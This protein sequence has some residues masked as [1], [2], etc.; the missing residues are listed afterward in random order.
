LWGVLFA[1]LVMSGCSHSMGG[2][3]QIPEMQSGQLGSR[4]AMSVISTNGST[5]TVTGT[6]EGGTASKFNVNAGSGC[7]MVNVTTTSSTA[8][9]YNGLTLSAG[10]PVTFTATG[11]CGTQFAASSVTLGTTS[12]P[13]LTGTIYAVNGSTINVQG[14]SGCG[15]VNVTYTGSTTINKN[16]YNLAAGVPISLWGS[17]SCSTS[18]SATQITLGPTTSNSPNLSGTIEAVSGSTIN[19]QGGSGC[20][21]VN[22][23][24]N[25]STK[26]NYNGDTLS[27]GTSIQVWG[28]GSCSSSFSASTIT[29]GSGSS[30]QSGSTISQKHVLTADYLGGAYGSN[31]VSWTTAATVLSWGEVSPSQA[32]AISDAGI[33]TMDYI[34]PFRQASTDPL[35]SSDS[36]TFSKNCSGG[37]L[38][39]T[40]SGTTMHLMNPASS[41]LESKMNSWQA[42][43]ESQGHYDAFYYDDIDTLYG[44]PTPCNMTQSIWDA[45]NSSF[46]E[47][48]ANPVIFSG[49]GMNSDSG[50]LINLS[51][52]LGGVIEDCY[53]TTG[54]PTPPYTSGSGWTGNENLQLAAG[55]AGKLFFCYNTPTTEGSSSIAVRNYIYAS[56]LM[57]Y[58]A[59]SSVLWEYFATPSGLRVFPETELVPTSPLV[60]GTTVASFEKSTGVYVREYSACYIKGSSIGHC[61]AVVNSDTASHPKPS[62][63]YSYSHTMSLSGNGI[64]DGGTISA[65]GGAAPSTLPAES[66]YILI[67]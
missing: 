28:S 34:D 46:I 41:D 32:N 24:Y 26:I 60:S 15:Y 55:A 38:S 9:A 22:V 30:G 31:S 36:S 11:S 13:N 40:Y 45:E 21:L 23:T 53:G 4:S 62:L 65:S 37:S 19:V 7:G 50:K 16:G 6:I 49:Y 10:T 35:Y 64:V 52:A 14:G 48:S 57:S 25:G 61:A 27:A 43:Q 44:A 20:G 18:F 8:W 5:S 67:Q 51:K 58:T 1:A 54:N 63:S 59:T 56:F 17:G 33:K 66:G 42:S 12:S 3:S 39:F 2:T 47:S 29:L